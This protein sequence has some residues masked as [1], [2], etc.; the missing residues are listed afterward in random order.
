MHTVIVGHSLPYARAHT[1]PT[2]EVKFQIDGVTREI[3][4]YYPHEWPLMGM[5]IRDWV[6]EGKIIQPI[7][8]APKLPITN[9]FN[10]RIDG[11]L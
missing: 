2:I 5:R 1:E 9:E 8:T 6:E 3:R 7:E 4:A 10:L 11:T